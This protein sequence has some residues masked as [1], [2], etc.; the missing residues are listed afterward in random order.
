M[1]EAI[2]SCLKK[3]FRN[4]AGS[5][6]TMAAL[7]A[8]PAMG[9][10]G[11]GLDMMRWSNAQTTLAAAMDGAVLSGTQYLVE[12]DNNTAAAIAVADAYFASAVKDGI[13]SENTVKF[14]LNSKGNGLAAYGNVE[15]E[16]SFLKVVGIDKMTVLSENVA[17]AAIAEAGASAPSADLEISLMLDVTGSMCN[18]N[19][20]PCTNDAKIAALKEAA[21]TLVET[22]VWADQSK[23]TSKIAIVPFSTRVRVGPDG[24]GA[25]MMK[26]LTNLDAKWSG[27]FKECVAGTGGGGSEG[28]GN[29]VCTNF[30]TH[31]VNNWKVMPCVTDRFYNASNSFE[32]TD[33]VPGSN[34]WLNAHDGGRMILGEDS[35][36]TAATVRLGKKKADAAD[37]WNYMPEGSCG[38]VAQ[39]NEIMPLSNNKSALLSKIAALEAFGSTG[40]VLGTAFSWY[41]LSPEW[42]TVWPADSEPKSYAKLIELNADNKPKLRKVAIMMTDGSYNTFR[43][44]KGQDVKLL[45]DNAKELCTNMKAKGIEIYTVGFALDSLPPAEIPVAREM[46]QSCGSGLDH[47]YNSINATAL[48]DAFTDIS[49][50]VTES[51]TRLTK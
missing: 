37:H 49:Q 1:R 30:A 18:D 6:S 17:E 5:V 8:V 26:K 27:W 10:V 14:K 28:D 11:A 48:K 34:F 36:S 13:F 15:I 33:K 7:S 21:T 2:M 4:T 38:D 51:Y 45:S 44:W 19:T 20:G 47:F 43:G 23:F 35:S 46:L 25:A 31:V 32:L 39:A 24:G 9:A 22:V 40:G 29:W 41:M 3:F 42:K 16:T 50:N 12:N